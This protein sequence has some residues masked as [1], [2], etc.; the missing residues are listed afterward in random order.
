MHQNPIVRNNA[1]R[2]GTW[3]NILSILPTRQAH[4][5]LL[6][7]SPYIVLCCW[8]WWRGCISCRS[9]WV[10]KVTRVCIQFLPLLWILSFFYLSTQLAPSRWVPHDELGSGPGLC[11]LPW[12]IFNCYWCYVNKS[13]WIELQ[14]MSAM[15]WGVWMCVCVCVCVCVWERVRQRACVCVCVCA[16]VCNR[17]S[18]TE[19]M[20]LC[21]CLCVCV[22]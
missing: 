19:S 15:G 13:N 12:D 4:F 5:L 7:L 20:C 8:H 6:L 14:T 18:E 21:V 22:R 2:S 3:C 9:N 16:Y 11:K 1:S 17:E 10:F